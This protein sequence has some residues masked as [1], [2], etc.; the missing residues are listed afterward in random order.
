MSLQ[1]CTNLNNDNETND[2]K[3]IKNLKNL[4]ALDLYRT[5]CDQESLNEILTS[6]NQIKHLNLGSCTKI[7]DFDDIIQTVAKNCKQIQSLDLWR[8]YSLTARGDF[9]NNN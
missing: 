5:Y 7:T 9:L 1:S 4:I 6:C 3:V 8:A 2:F